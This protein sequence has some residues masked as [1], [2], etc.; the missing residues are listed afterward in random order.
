MNKLP[1]GSLAGQVEANKKEFRQFA[2]HVQRFINVT[3]DRFRD[4][5]GAFAEALYNHE[6][7]IKELEAKLEIKPVQELQDQ[8]AQVIADTAVPEPQVEAENKEPELPGMPDKPVSQDMLLNG[9]QELPEEPMKQESKI[10]YHKT[11]D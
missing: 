10:K 9:N 5:Q 11:F 7:R 1:T 6:I 3:Q 8:L 4:V 2:N